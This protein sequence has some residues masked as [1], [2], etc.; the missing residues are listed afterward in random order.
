MTET[1]KP[2]PFCGDQP[3]IF[4][5]TGP[6]LARYSH[7]ESPSRF[8]D[9][10][11]NAYCWK[12]HDALIARNEE[13]VGALKSTQRALETIANPK[14]DGANCSGHFNTVDCIQDDIEQILAKAS[15]PRKKASDYKYR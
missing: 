12:A 8:L 13:L 9:Q 4:E 6:D 10:W 2:C 15:E 3:N 1:L 14:D 7:C 5:R 11:N